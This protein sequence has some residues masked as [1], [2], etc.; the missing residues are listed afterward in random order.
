[1]LTIQGEGF[2]SRAVDKKILSVAQP[3]GYGATVRRSI[4]GRQLSSFDPFLLL[5]EFNVGA[6]AG[7]PD[8]PHRGFE[9][10]TYMLPSSEG[11]FE[12]EDFEG[13]HGVIGPGDLQWMTAGKGIL[14][15]EMPKNDKVSH[16]LQ[17]W[18]NLSSKDK[19]CPP[20]Y[21]ELPVA[22][23]PV[24]TTEGVT[25]RVI[26]GTALG[27]TSPVYTRT[28][29]S[30]LHFEM[31]ASTTLE[32]PI[33]AD[34]NAF[35][36]V[37]DGSATFGTGDKA[38]ESQAHHTLTLTRGTE[39]GVTVVAGEK[40]CNF[41]LIAG[42]P[43]GEPVVQRGPFVMNTEEE[44]EQTFHDFH[45]GTNGFEKAPGWKSEIGKRIKRR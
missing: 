5:D 12:H 27:A 11:V 28:P 29:T 43:T 39:A 20:A 15:S 22:K 16:G 14:H 2:T 42:K 31:G 34:W 10:V 26:A 1:M 4:G 33:S 30:F 32:Q 9:T 17:L 8:H 3:E 6:P 7:F 24:V 13:H 44:I 45:S 37:L 18:V 36:Y 23:I 40:G 21:Q 41:V 35:I 25:A 19:M 38:V